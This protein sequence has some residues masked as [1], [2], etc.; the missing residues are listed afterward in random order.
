MKKRWDEPYLKKTKYNDKILLKR[1][2]FLHTYC[3]HCGRSLIEDNKIVLTALTVTFFLSL[4]FYFCSYEQIEIFLQHTS[5]QA[6][7]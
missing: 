3:P 7:C 4:A 2:T 1:G 5:M 6:A